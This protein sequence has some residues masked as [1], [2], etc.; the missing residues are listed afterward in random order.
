VITITAL[1]PCLGAEVHGVD[2]TKP[3]SHTDFQQIVSAFDRHSVL[4]FPSQPITDEQQI[5]FSEMFGKL[6][7]R[8]TYA[9]ERERIPLPQVNDISNVDHEGKLLS[10]D[11]RQRMFTLGNLLWHTDSSFKQIPSICSLLSGREVSPEGGETEFADMRAAYDALGP[12]R[13]RALDGLIVEHSIYHSR[14]QTGFADFNDSIFSKMPPVQQMLVRRHPGSGRMSLYL[15]SHASHIIGWPVETG[16]ALIAEL[17]AFA[18]QPRFVYSHTWRTNDLVMWD[19]RCTMHRGRPYDDL[20]YR[21]VMHRTTVQDIANTVDQVRSATA[22]EH[23]GAA[24][25]A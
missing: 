17:M 5:T 2:L 21:R 24:L 6:E 16:R 25:P 11:D 14:S 10:P 3:V 4:I 20:K 23:A 19:N 12:E 8:N 1:H 22:R 15:A 18:T 9:R 13:Q 7:I